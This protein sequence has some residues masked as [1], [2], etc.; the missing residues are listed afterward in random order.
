[1]S[2]NHSLKP[3]EGEV[4]LEHS[5][6]SGLI[7]GTIAPMWHTVVLIAGILALSIGER[8]QFT[9]MHREP[10]RLLTYGETVAMEILMLGWVAFGLRLR[11]LPLRSLFGHVTKGLRGIAIDLG[12][13]F[14][15]WIGSLTI[16]ATLG[17]LWTG[18]EM[19]IKQGHIPIHAGQPLEPSPE[20]KQ[21]VR[22]LEQ[23]APANTTEV[24]SW[25]ALCL[26]AGLI[27]E[28]V[29]RGYLQHQFTAWARGELAA[30]VAFSALLFGAAHGYQGVRNM[31]LL[32]VFGVLFSL[33]AISR[34]GLR[35]GIFAHG[36]HD[37]IAG[38]A[39]A[40]L[41]AHHLV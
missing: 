38:L 24:A 39:L 2:E 29:F 1:M 6:G 41:R 8:A 22:M 9:Q 21:T 3:A 31:V 13:A 11:K 5:V 17:I 32:A 28:A 16:L 19:A 15:F 25:V 18:V 12:I 23:L 40:A 14:L 26:I 35:A 36:W 7:A 37:M 34:R 27:E 30:G 10:G 20:E 4:P 33:L